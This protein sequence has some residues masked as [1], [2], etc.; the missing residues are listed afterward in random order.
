M[1]RL[2]EIKARCEKATEGEWTV[3]DMPGERPGLRCIQV[4]G[5][6]GR[7]WLIPVCTTGTHWQEQPGQRDMTDAGFIAHS[8]AD[9]PYLVALVER[10]EAALRDAFDS[11]AALAREVLRLREGLRE[12]KNLVCDQEPTDAK[13]VELTE[14]WT[15][16]LLA[17]REW[18]DGGDKQ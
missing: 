9:I 1:S 5:R 10:L 3:E 11:R 13:V 12:V 7:G 16:N 15:D 2:D 8:R 6:D 17:G 4:A 18:K 14:R